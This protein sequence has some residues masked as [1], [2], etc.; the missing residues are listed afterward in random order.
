MEGIIP[1]MEAILITT[2]PIPLRIIPILPIQAM[3]ALITTIPTTIDDLLNTAKIITLRVG[4]GRIRT[5]MNPEERLLVKEAAT[6]AD[7]SLSVQAPYQDWVS[8]N[9]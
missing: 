8:G 7:S 4:Q 2:T 6:G 5:E 1:K 3:V 9:V